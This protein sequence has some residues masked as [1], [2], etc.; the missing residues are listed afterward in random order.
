VPLHSYVAGT[1]RPVVVLPS[2]SLDSTAMRA[3]F[4]PAFAGISGW[5]RVYL[6]LPGS[7][8]SPPGEPT[9]DAVL[10]DVVATVD[11]LLGGEPF[12]IAG[13]S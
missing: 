3:A 10:A 2:L 4:E 11:A 7:G 1:G 5:S 13:W 8:G 12:P 9:S 6:D